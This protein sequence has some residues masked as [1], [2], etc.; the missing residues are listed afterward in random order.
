MLALQRVGSTF[1]CVAINFSVCTATVL[2]APPS[3]E[4][5][6]LPVVDESI[7]SSLEPGFFTCERD[8]HSENELGTPLSSGCEDSESCIQNSTQ[9]IVDRLLAMPNR[10]FDSSKPISFFT[11]YAFLYMCPLFHSARAGPV[12]QQAI[13]ALYL[14]VKRE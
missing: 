8:A 6:F 4:F 5:P 9:M 2:S 13:V 10:V 14:T 1:L 7:L 12:H 3:E 11:E